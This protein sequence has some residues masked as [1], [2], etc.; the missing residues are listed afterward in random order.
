VKGLAWIIGLWLAVSCA[1][2]GV[3]FAS[4][5]IA[6]A[7]R[8][9]LAYLASD[10][11]TDS[12]RAQAKLLRAVE[13]KFSATLREGLENPSTGKI[14]AKTKM[15]DDGQVQVLAQMDAKNIFGEMA[16]SYWR[17]VYD[18]ETLALTSFEMLE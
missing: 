8:S 10:G 6:D 16:R 18:T 12:Q 13:T 3:Y 11:L 7:V 1:L 4:R 14:V 17:G 5:P 15:L 9:S 2:L